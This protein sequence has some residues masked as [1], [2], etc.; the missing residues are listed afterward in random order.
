[1]EQNEG[2][3]VL[4]TDIPSPQGMLGIIVLYNAAKIENDSFV[5]RHVQR[6]TSV[7]RSSSVVKTLHGGSSGR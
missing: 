1:M 2:T 5:V 4:T 3:A 6:G 7:I